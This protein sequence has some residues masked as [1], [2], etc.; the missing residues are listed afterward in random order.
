MIVDVDGKFAI[1]EIN[2]GQ[3]EHSLFPHHPAPFCA[4]PTRQP[5][6]ERQMQG[7]QRRPQRRETAMAVWTVLTR[8]LSGGT[9]GRTT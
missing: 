3:S 7:R 1:I 8:I 9:T 5:D 4:V 6:I 2:A